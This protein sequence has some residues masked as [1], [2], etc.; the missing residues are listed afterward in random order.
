MAIPDFQ[1]VMLPIMETL[2]DGQT[3][4]MRNLTQALADRFTLS[5]AERQQLLP[6]GQ[7]T[8][9]SNRV[10]WAKA[11]LK[12]AGLLESPARGSVKI[13]DRGKEA[14]ATKPAK[15][16][17]A[18][19]RQFPGYIEAARP[20]E[21]ES[22]AD[23]ETATEPAATQTPEEL[24]EASFEELRDTLAKDLLEKVQTASPGF[25]E[26]LV[27]QLLVAM[28]Y[29][30]SLADAGQAIGRSGDEGIDGIIK[31]DKLGL[32][33]VCIQAKRWKNQVG[34]PQVQAFAGSMEGYRARKGVLITTATFSSDAREYVNKI[35]RKIVLIDGQTLASYM[36][37]YGIGV[38]TAQVY[39]LK[40][41]DSDFF[42]EEA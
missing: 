7:Q 32:D 25:F 16:N 33:V 5:D 12:M 15:I 35:E 34:R 11:H 40:K 24:L 27:V 4:I 28:G 17:L 36:I 30:G 29:G 20:N 26:R 2:S 19:L 8:V 31:E 42:T 10:A 38:S 1:S 6:S 13:S 39:T 23:T 41:L 9:F 22:A 18:Y 37:D 3:W 21:N 14:L